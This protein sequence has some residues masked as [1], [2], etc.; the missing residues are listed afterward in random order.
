MLLCVLAAS[1]AAWKLWLRRAG[2]PLLAHSLLA[3][4]R[5]HALRL[6]SLSSPARSHLYEHPDHRL[7]ANKA[8]APLPS[9]F[10]LLPARLA[11][12]LHPFASL[13]A[14]S[15]VVPLARR[16]H[17]PVRHGRQSTGSQ[18]G[19]RNANQS[20]VL[21]RSCK[22]SSVHSQEALARQVRP[23]GWLAFRRRRVRPTLTSSSSSLRPPSSL[24]HSFAPGSSTCPRS[25]SRGLSPTLTSTLGRDL[26]ALPLW[27]CT[28]CSERRSWSTRTR[29][30]QKA[31]SS[32][33]RRK[34]SRAGQADGTRMAGNRGL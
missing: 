26:L 11:C 1:P 17:G 27:S 13:P 12:T 15:A 22:E 29:R 9:N 16:R 23:H 5:L 30:P 25:S 28:S 24:T 14:L 32:G 34:Q 3:C 7:P 33:P 18:A 19:I 21:T 2:S 4:S 20:S 8:L 31:A 6:L 10:D